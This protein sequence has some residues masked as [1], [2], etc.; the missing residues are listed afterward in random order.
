VTLIYF[1][2]N[3]DE[4]LTNAASVVF[5][6]PDAEFGLKRTDTDEVLVD[7]GTAFTN[8]STGVYQYELDDPAEELGYEYW[9]KIVDVVGE[10]PIYVHRFVNSGDGGPK[11]L[12][13]VAIALGA[14]IVFDTAPQ[15]SSPNADFGLKRLDTEAVVVSDGTSYTHVSGGKYAATFTEPADD[16]IYRYY[17]ECEYGDITYYLPRTTNLIDSAYLA[18]GRYT[19]SYQIEQAF[20]IDNL[21]KWLAIDDHDEAVDYALRAYR[22]IAD[23]EAE[24]DDLLRGG[25]CTVPFTVVPSV[26]SKIATNMAAVRMYEARGVVD[27]DDDTGAVRHRLGFAAKWADKE[28]GR[29]KSGQ[30]RLAVENV[31]RYPTIVKDC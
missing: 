24:V 3:V 1:E 29:I 31:R 20:G 26:I 6:D 12:K 23:A 14:A 11:V 2:W 10:P 22:F 27:T 21:H 9:I 25:P 19:D 4:T 30:L 13:F 5:E 8:P 28:I 7:A 15:L 16:L 18:I 17:V